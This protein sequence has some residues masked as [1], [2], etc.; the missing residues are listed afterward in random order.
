VNKYTHC[1]SQVIFQGLKTTLQILEVIFNVA[2]H[3][4]ATSAQHHY[5]HFLFSRLAACDWWFLQ[6]APTDPLPAPHTTWRCCH[7]STTDCYSSIFA[8]VCAGWNHRRFISA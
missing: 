7:G 4:L 3:Q 2:E 8:V 5:F 6:H 1:Y